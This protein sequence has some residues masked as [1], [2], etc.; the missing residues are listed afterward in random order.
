MPTTMR[1]A[2]AAVRRTFDNEGWKYDYN[3]EDNVF[4][5]KFSLKKTKLSTIR[6][7]VRCAPSSRSPGDCLRISSFG[8]IPMK[9]DDDCKIQVSEYLTR[10][11]Y[12]LALGNFEMDFSDGEVSFRY[13]CNVLDG[14]IGE[15]ALDDLTTLPIAMFEKYGNGLLAVMMGMMTPEEAIRQA[16][17]N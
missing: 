14:M 2:V 9:A 4:S 6:I 12:K 11:N 13:A 5:I 3:A 1:E 8:Y 15:D 16:D 17:S 10:I 7:I